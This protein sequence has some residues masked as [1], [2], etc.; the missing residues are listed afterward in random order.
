VA[1]LVA[2]GVLVREVLQEDRPPATAAEVFGSP[3]ART[4]TVSI[5]GG[6]A[7]IGLSRE[8]GLMAFDAAE[9]PPLPRGRVYQLW[10]IDERGP[11][12]AGVVDP[13]GLTLP[14]P[15]GDAQVALT[16]EPE[17]GSEEPTTRPLF[18]VQPSDL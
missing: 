10:V 17:G 11:H 6:E 5:R 15:Q 8:L 18:T 12:S 14:I 1:A 16:T 2:G 3:D 7:R 13:P 4:T 9:V